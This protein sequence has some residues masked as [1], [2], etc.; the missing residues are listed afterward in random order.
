MHPL[1]QSLLQLLSA[2][3]NVVVALG[4]L[5]VPFLPLVA[6]VAFWLFAVNWTKLR[7]VLLQ[8]GWIGLLLIGLV[9]VLIWGTVSQPPSGVH[10]FLGLTLGN[11]VGKTVLVTTLICI[12]FLCGSVQLSGSCGQWCQFDEP[13]AETSHGG[14][15]H[16]NGSHGH[17]AD[18]HSHNGHGASGHH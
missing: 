14:H 17:A 2:L 12:M 6:W 1:D 7:V 9:A 10:Q 11:F 18:S 13:A 16:A 4:A 8:G 3:G 5:V 15:S